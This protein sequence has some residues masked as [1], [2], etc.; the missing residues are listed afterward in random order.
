MHPVEK[1][2]RTLLENRGT[3][4]AE[5]SNYAALAALLDSA[6]NQLKPRVRCV[7]HPKGSGSGIPDAGLFTY[8]Q[9]LHSGDEPLPGMLP[10]RGAVEAK[11]ISAGARQ[12]ATSEQVSKY[13]EKYGQV[14]VTTFR[15]WVLVER[16]LDRKP[17]PTESFRIA[18][19]EA[20]FWRAAAD[21]RATAEALGD[22]LIEFLQR[23]LLR[24]APLADP[25]DV[26]WLLAAYARD[27]RFRVIQ[28]GNLPALASVRE[29]LEEALG[30]S[31]RGEQG[32]HF[33]RSTLV[34]TLFY[35][36]FSAWT[37]WSREGGRNVFDWKTALWH[38]RVPVIGAL[39][40]QIATPSRLGPLK[41]VEVLDWAADALNRVDR[42]AFFSRFE[43]QHAVQYFY[44][45]FLEAFDPELRKDL[46]V[47][48][49]PPELV[50]YMVARVDIALR[51]ELGITDGLA[52]PRVLVLDPCCGTGTFLVE[53]LEKIAENLRS[54]GED[55]LLAIEVRRAAAERVFGFEILPAPF[56]VAHLQL[57]LLL[58]RM[59]APELEG[60][61]KPRV[62][63]FLT[64]ALTGWEPPDEQ[65]HLAFP[66]LEAERDASDR[67]K[68][69][70]RIL[71]VLGNPPYN[72]Y[73][74]L[75]IGEERGLVEA[76]RETKHASKPQGR[77][78]NDL[79]VRFFRMAERRI[80][81]MTGTGVICFISNYSW[82]DGLSFTGM[83]E[84]YLNVFDH[85]WIDSL[86]GDRFRT[87]KLTPEGEPDPS[88]FSTEW[89]REGIQLGTA[90]SLLVRTKPHEG[91]R[92]IKFR[93]LWG[94]NKRQ[95]LQRSLES[96][97]DLSYQQIEPAVE[98]G[99]PFMPRDVHASYLSWPRFPELFPAFFAGVQTNRDAALVDIDRERL[100]R[101]MEA[102][103]DPH[104]PDEDVRKL[105]P[106]ITNPAAR[107]DWKPIRDYL[108]RRGIK[109]NNFF[110]YYYRPLDIRWLYW[111]PE[112]KLLNEKRA[113]YIPHVFEPNVWIVTQQQPRRDWNPPQVITGLGCLDLMDRSASFFPLL[114]AAPEH[115]Q[116]LF[117]DHEERRPRPNVSDVSSRYLTQT[118]ATAEE[119]F[120]HSIAILHAPDYREENADSLRQDWP[121]VPLPTDRVHLIA[122]AHLGKEL[123]TLLDPKLPVL[124]VS[125]GAKRS[126]LRVL[127]ASARV[128]GRQLSEEDFAITAGWGFAG[129]N[130]VVMPGRGQTDER[131]WG[132]EEYAAVEAGALTLGLDPAEAVAL[133]GN[134]VLDVYL[135][136]YAFWQCVPKHVWEYTLGGYQVIKKWLSY[137]EQ[138]LL[139]RP[140]NMDEVREVTTMVRRIA[141]ILLMAPALNGAYAAAKGAT[142]IKWTT[143][144]K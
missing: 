131:S 21:P 63:V 98:L 46:G 37:L 115:P 122:A 33:F 1:Y 68:R 114:L 66:E 4:V 144:I 38:L 100:D 24:P 31:F 106:A 52:D 54:C 95:E 76:Y 126:E 105:A 118:G 3:G 57:K 142:D 28:H 103:F 74:G 23:A 41:L 93:N 55:A 121:R 8:E 94:K 119:L 60:M 133:L 101:R 139:D 83:R 62:G 30:V 12:A 127:G 18:E 50:K 134:T 67:V 120:Y 132:V 90:I 78:L 117:D 44:E 59:G 112:T 109:S 10:E 69:D 26:A 125:I 84:R 42:A 88:V 40:A 49:T 82:L 14:L 137:R 136:E 113:E 58:A 51:D 141:A 61:E 99:Y 104:I 22:R 108:A 116:S 135:N 47:W 25:K 16:G 96:D 5:T 35:G 7:L 29:A 73:P 6:G 107:F 36:V 129:R 32:D 80:V 39:F 19:T 77:G 86:N 130:G 97:L 72:G 85:M 123:A 34:Q 65:K 13:L 64:N 87:G 17:L 43:Q 9:L 71:V 138:S 48:Y 75:A 81:E 2:L 53:V 89:N 92:S 110:Q 15:D 124:G 56:V 11:P 128:G 91:A 27:A 79:Y 143:Y 45:P 70:S 102:Y 111:E 140:L 20:E